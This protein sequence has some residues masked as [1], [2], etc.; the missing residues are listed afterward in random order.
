M[1]AWGHGP[2][3]NDA[4]YDYLA[5]LRDG[6]TTAVPDALRRT[7]TAFLASQTVEAKSADQAITA[8]A[9]I[10]MRAGAAASV[11]GTV[12]DFLESHPFAWDDEMRTLASKAFTHALEAENNEWLEIWEDSA[13]KVAQELEPFRQAVTTT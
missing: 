7:L 10:A 5:D 4:A 6:G 13:G 12:Q 1:G 8:A 3:E 11:S 9:L 2:F